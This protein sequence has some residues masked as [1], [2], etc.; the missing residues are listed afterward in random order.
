[1]TDKSS[2]TM[3][4]RLRTLSP[5]KREIL[6]R[7]LERAG[8]TSAEASV[9]IAK[10]AG[11]QMQPL[12]PSQ[13]QVWF[14]EQ[15][16]TQGTA[17]N[18]SFA[19]KLTGNLDVSALQKS[20]EEL[21]FRHQMLRARILHKN[22]MIMQEVQA[23]A[24]LAVPVMDLRALNEDS[25]QNELRRIM[26]MEACQAF[27]LGTS[28][29]LRLKVV[30][31]ASQQHFCLLT[32]HHIAADGWSIGIIVNE[33]SQLYGAYFA[34]HS[35]PLEPLPV[36]YMD[37]VHAHL[38]SLK[39]SPDEEHLDYWREQYAELPEPLRLPLR[40]VVDDCAASEVARAPVNIS[41]VL[42][43]ELRRLGRLEDAT[44]FIVLMAGFQLLL[45]VCTDQND[46][47]V[48]VP[49]AN[50]TRPFSDR[51][52][53][54]FVTLLPVRI[55][56]RNRAISF[57]GLLKSVRETMLAAY[58]HQEVPF[59]RLLESLRLDRTERTQPLVQAVLSMDDLPR[60]PPTQEIAGLRMTP[61]VL[62]NEAAKFDWVLNLVQ[63][64]VGIQGWLEYDRKY[65]S[66]T[67]IARAVKKYVQILQDAVK[68]PDTPLDQ[69][70]WTR[71]SDLEIGDESLSAT[72]AF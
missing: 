48:G 13:L 63:L 19:M 45:S 36:Q 12:L 47:V 53:G 29:L 6:L 8:R 23:A 46:I 32:V 5:A 44:P 72:F 30:R 39:N 52:V 50:R 43:D 54:M 65:F 21:A 33:L 26:R 37:Y 68:A 69:V 51:L 20:A 10:S 15:Q 14:H 28:P 66:P 25:S 62:E 16:A 4:D 17:N 38:Q 59:E 40:G 41:A 60:L 35:S 71:S 57:R 70:L 64:E 56:L 1:M 24:G 58:A 55:Q 2:S 9:P 7:K 31:T 22:G 11:E 61:I 42:R 18:L 27:D 67:T 49:I 34:G 3:G